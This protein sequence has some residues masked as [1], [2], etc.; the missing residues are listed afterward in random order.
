LIRDGDRLATAIHL[1]TAASCHP[2]LIQRSFCRTNTS[3]ARRD[4]YGRPV[5]VDV[6]RCADVLL[7]LHIPVIHA[8]ALLV[9]FVREG[10][11][12]LWLF[13]NH[14]MMGPPAP[15]GYTWS[16]PLLYLVFACVIALLYF[17]CR[18]FADLQAR[19]RDSWLAYI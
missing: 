7:P 13:A 15:P 12:D 18:W 6:R 8:A 4:P 10:H 1:A 14:P 5:P 17:P 3:V 16:L 19:R 9:S 11:A 2:V